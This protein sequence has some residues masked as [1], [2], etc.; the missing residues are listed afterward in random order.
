MYLNYRA[1]CLR[2]LEHQFMHIKQGECMCFLSS[3]LCTLRS[4]TILILYIYYSSEVYMSQALPLCVLTCTYIYISERLASD[5]DTQTFAALISKSTVSTE[6]AC[7]SSAC[8]Q[9]IYFNRT[10]SVRQSICLTS[11][12]QVGHQHLVLLCR[13]WKQQTALTAVLVV[14][15][16][17][18]H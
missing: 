3:T 13:C 10:V 9:A 6:H 17:A 14:V 7:A 12:T 15:A 5:R 4:T 8:T 2:T 1:S 18:V 11:Q 16:V